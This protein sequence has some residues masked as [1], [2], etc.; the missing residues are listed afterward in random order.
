MAQV[1][2]FGYC[3]FKK[4]RQIIIDNFPTNKPINGYIRR[5][6]CVRLLSAQMANI[7]R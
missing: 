7:V 1:L 3:H 5:Q 2:L 6:V 4:K